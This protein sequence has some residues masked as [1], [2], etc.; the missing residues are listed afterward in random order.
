MGGRQQDSGTKDVLEFGGG[1]TMDDLVVQRS[2]ND[3]LVGVKAKDA[4][5]VADLS[6]LTD[7]V[8]I[9]DDANSKNKVEELAFFGGVRVSL[10]DVISTFGV[11]AGGAAVDLSAPKSRGQ[12]S[13]TDGSDALHGGLGSDTY[14][15][16]RDGLQDDTM[17]DTGGTDSVVFD[18]V[19]ANNLWLTRNGDDLHLSLLDKD[20]QLTVED[21][22]AG[23]ATRVESFGFGGVYVNANNGVFAASF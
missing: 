3:L 21:H 8:R 5:A 22:F 12:M 23:A 15:F 6:G 9:K 16:R 10:S 18:D 2:G 7:V 20:G 14:R 4:S 13:T 17:R 19:V 11:V 1:I